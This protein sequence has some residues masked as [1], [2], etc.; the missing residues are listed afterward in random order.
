MRRRDELCVIGA[1]GF[2]LNRRRL[3]RTGAAATGMAVLGLIPSSIRPGRFVRA[4][5]TI[6]VLAPQWPQGAKEQALAEEWSKDSGVAVVFDA[7]P[8]Q[9][10]VPPAPVGRDGPVVAD[11]AGFQE[12][13]WR[14]HGAEHAAEAGRLKTPDKSLSRPRRTFAYAHAIASWEIR[15]RPSKRAAGARLP[16]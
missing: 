2:R 10:V 11:V 9:G 3:L 1:A 16:R 12:E 8:D 4:D 15:P 7:R 14:L 13:G 6:N 5:T